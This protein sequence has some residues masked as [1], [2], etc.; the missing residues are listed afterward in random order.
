MSSRRPSWKGRWRRGLRAALLHCWGF[1]LPE[2]GGTWAWPALRPGGTRFRPRSPGG[3]SESRSFTR[4]S[5]WRGLFWL[6]VVTTPHGRSGGQPKMRAEPGIGPSLHGAG[7]SWR[8]ARLQGPGLGLGPPLASRLPASGTQGGDGS[9]AFSEGPLAVVSVRR[10]C[11]GVGGSVA[12]V[13]WERLILAPV[14]SF[15]GLRRL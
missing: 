3:A 5:T 15:P 8:G 6:R 2:A 12:V 11:F 9:E 4:P 1:G 13:V 14:L 7:V 10:V